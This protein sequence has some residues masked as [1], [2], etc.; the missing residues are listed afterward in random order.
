MDNIKILK[1]YNNLY[2]IIKEPARDKK[3][4]NK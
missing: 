1:K 4:K 3:I 2:R